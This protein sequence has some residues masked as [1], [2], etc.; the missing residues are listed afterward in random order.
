[1]G[2][3]GKNDKEAD[4]TP[5]DLV[6]ET[7]RARQAE[8]RASGVMG[9]VPEPDYDPLHAWKKR[10]KE[11]PIT[12]ETLHD[13]LLVVSHFAEA[14]IEGGIRMSADL[15]K[16][17]PSIEQSAT[18]FRVLSSKI[19]SAASYA[20]KVDEDLAKTNKVINSLRR[21]MQLIRDDVREVKETVRYLPAIKEMLGEILTRLPES[22]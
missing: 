20:D 13:G 7:I 4:R 21:D 16:A 9:T 8:E 11:E 19:E 18:Q 2:K 5:L 1:M 14:A 15:R 17:L 3:N 10:V 12:L 22:K 6:E